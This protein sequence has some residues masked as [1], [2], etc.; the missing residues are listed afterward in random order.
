MNP[1]Y[2]TVWNYRR[3]ILREQITK[4]RLSQSTERQALGDDHVKSISDWIVSDL[5]FI[6]PLLRKYPK[7][8]W[9]WKYRLWLLNEATAVLPSDA[10]KKLWREE[11][12]LVNHMLN[13]DRRNFHGWGYRRIVIAAIEKG[14]ADEPGP[15]P[16]KT[17]TGLSMVEEEFRYTTTMIQTDLSNFSA[18]HNRSKLIPKLLDER[19]AD[20]ATRQTFLD[21]GTL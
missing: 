19:R 13:R 16:W 15:E 1:E 8:Y 21:E 6:I 18:W 14:N 10:A 11:L 20:A 2:Y 9:I 12:G 4:S 17:T 7:C 5:Q 3:I